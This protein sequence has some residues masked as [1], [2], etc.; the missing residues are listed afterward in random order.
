MNRTQK[1]IIGCDI[2]GVLA[3]F[4]PAF[5]DLLNDHHGT[6]CRA[7]HV[8]EFE[9]EECLPVTREQVSQ[10]WERVCPAFWESLSPIDGAKEGLRELWAL[11]PVWLITARRPAAYQATHSWLMEH[12]FY[13]DSLI[14][15]A[16][17][18][19]FADHVSVMVEDKW[20]EA[21]RFADHGTPVVL[22]DYP[23]NCKGEHPLIHRAADWSQVVEKILRIVTN[24]K[25][26]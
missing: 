17:K 11:A 5:L 20:A 1:T 15:T 13:Y 10:T 8:A 26:T 14:S 19:A 12:G 2:D 21:C 18:L 3:S 9:F 25:T 22:M 6:D 4:T 7:E 24:T 16:D 23:H